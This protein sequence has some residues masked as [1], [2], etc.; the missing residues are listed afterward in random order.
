MNARNLIGLSNKAQK[1]DVVVFVLRA[2]SPCA[3]F[4]RVFIKRTTTTDLH[5]F[6]SVQ[7]LSDETK[8]RESLKT[9]LPIY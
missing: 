4:S 1:Q 5:L 6:V 8:P 3:V 7:E 2:A 9:A